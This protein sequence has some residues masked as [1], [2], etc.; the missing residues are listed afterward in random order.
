MSNLPNILTIA[1]VLLVPIFALIYFIPHKSSVIWAMGVFILAG[2]TDVLDG[3]IAR[4]YDAVSN[5]GKLFDPLADKLMQCT[6]LICIFIDK[7]F[8]VWI[9]ALLL[10]KEF[11][12]IVGSAV[13]YKKHYVVHSVWV[14]KVGSIV[15]YIAVIY[16]AVIGDI[17]PEE[18]NEL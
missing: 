12:M 8:P 13:F 2:V 6:A 1:R 18:T 15:L 10:L 17:Y 11:L 4:K 16:K 3:Y 14:G 5:F 7:R 9:L